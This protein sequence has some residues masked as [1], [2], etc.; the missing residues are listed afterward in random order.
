M[1]VFPGLQFQRS[2]RTI[3]VASPY[4]PFPLSHGGAV[5]MYNLMRGAASE[6]NQILVAFCD[7]LATPTPNFGKFAAK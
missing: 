5:R 4:L 7:E 6:W 3:V 2:R 1:A